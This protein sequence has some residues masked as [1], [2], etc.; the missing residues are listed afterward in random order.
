MVKTVVLTLD[1]LAERTKTASR[2]CLKQLILKKKTHIV[3]LGALAL[4]IGV[5]VLVHFCFFRIDLTEDKRYSL[6][7]ATKEMLRGLDE[8]LEVRVLLDGQMNASFLKLR[9]ATTEMLDEMSIYANIR[10]TTEAPAQDEQ[11]L[12]GELP[13][14]VIHEK[15][16]GGQTVQTSLYPYAALRYKG[17]MTAVPLLKNN[18]GLSGEEN[19]NLSI[20]QLEFALA[21]GISSLRKAEVTKIAFLE[22]HGEL[23]EMHVY[24]LSLAL[25]KYFQV[26]RGSLTGNVADIMPYKAIVIADPKLP[27]S[28]EDK[29]QLDQYVM[30]GGRLLWALD[31]VRFSDDFLSSE[32][33]T[34]VIA[35]DLNVQDMLFR[36]GVRVSPTLLQDL[37]CLPVP[38]DVSQDPQ[39]PNWQPMPWY[40]APL[41]LTSQQS[42]ITKNLMQVSST[43]C[44]G[45][46]LVGG[47]DG[48]KKEVLLATSNASRAIGVPAEVD[49]SLIELDEEMFVHSFIPVG[50]SVEG[51]FQSLFAHRMAPEGVTPIKDQLKESVPTKQIVIASGS[52]IR[53]DVQQGQPLPAGYDR[54]TG[55]QFANKDLLVNALLY[56]ADDNDLINLRTKEVALRLINDKRAHKMR[57]TVQ[58]LTIALPLLILALVGGIFLTIRKKKY[59]Q[60]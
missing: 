34:P 51:C 26:D 7:D 42:A 46:E 53:A 36:W 12:I 6:Q 30:H 19:I 45:L 54:Y 23:D 40:Y 27:F 56:L 4:L 44:S 32:G 24:D 29:Y 1:K 57:S 20:E 25:S 33:F 49:L 58:A 14:T 10:Q 48:L 59:A 21:E 15:Q 2:A 28:E 8:Q 47:D 35:L 55:M 39:N 16:Q 31:G 37:Q 3:W 50:A 22:G 9:N 38:V 17:R 41:L 13:P 52:V 60:A 43:F 5:N 11:G 18:R